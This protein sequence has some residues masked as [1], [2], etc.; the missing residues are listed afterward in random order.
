MRILYVHN[1]YARPSGEE[2][3]SNSIVELLREHGHEVDFFKRSSAEI[4][5]SRLGR[6]KAFFTGISNPCAARAL[7]RKLDEYRPDLVQVQNLYP[8]LSPDV[9][10]PI[11]KRNIPVVMRCPNYRLFCPNGLCYNGSVCER[12][13]GGRE[14]NCFFH[15]CTGS[16]FKSLGYAV[17]G[18]A[19]RA[20]RRILDHVDVFI[21]QSEFQKQKFIEQGIP[22]GKIG[23]VPGLMPKLDAAES[24]TPGESITFVGRVSEEKGI[25]EFLDAA[26]R[27]PELPFAVAGSYDGMPGIEKT[28]PP[29]VTFLGFLQGEALRRA[30][31]NS[32]LI[33]VPSKWYEGFP[34]VI[35]MS[36]MLRK[37]TLTAAI[38]ATG[39]I[40]TDGVDG[41]LF[42][43]TDVPDLCEKLQSLYH[44]LPRC[45]AMGN[46]AQ[47]QAE[48][49]Y[50][51]EAIYRLLEEIYRG[52]VH[53]K[54]SS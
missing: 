11:K 34:N 12:C 53:S 20:T 8:L 23:I 29:N 54:V 50:S 24:W 36:M 7:A 3:A 45:E 19:A 39:S 28:A 17:R 44:D 35:V 30:Y 6:I 18:W 22:A 41:L 47:L 4:E 51:R 40:I 49:L 25:D 2:H 27:L 37:P 38:G 32:R 5:G 16:R 21:V 33:V 31:V 14:W 10:K 52:E 13:F 1:D 26:R 42:R 48:K 15:N 9:F 46:A 43:P